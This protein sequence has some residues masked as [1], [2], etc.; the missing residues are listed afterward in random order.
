ML[1]IF[2]ILFNPS[3]SAGSSVCLGFFCFFPDGM[4]DLRLRSADI[5][6]VTTHSVNINSELNPL[7]FIQTQSGDVMSQGNCLVVVKT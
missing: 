7:F 5:F 4:V 2:T 1:A 3:S 6:V